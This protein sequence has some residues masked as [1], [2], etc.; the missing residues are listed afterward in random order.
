MTRRQ[1]LVAVLLS[2]GI[3]LWWLGSRPRKS[4]LRPKQFPGS[5]LQERALDMITSPLKRIYFH[6]LKVA[7]TKNTIM[8]NSI[9]SKGG[10]ATAMLTCS[11]R[12]IAWDLGF[13]PDKIAMEFA[14][15]LRK[16]GLP[17]ETA[18]AQFCRRVRWRAAR[19]VDLECF[20]TPG[21]GGIVAPLLVRNCFGDNLLQQYIFKHP[22]AQAVI[23]GA[24]FDTRFYRL[25]FLSG[26]GNL[27]LLEVDTAETLI[28]KTTAL[29]TAQIKCDHVVFVPCNFNTQN[30][31]AVLSQHGFRK[32]SPAVIVWEGVSMYL[33]RA[34]VLAMF[35][36]VAKCAKGT[37]LYF[38]YITEAAAKSP[39]VHTGEPFAFGMKDISKPALEE[40]VHLVPGLLVREHYPFAVLYERYVPRRADGHFISPVP[41]ISAIAVLEVA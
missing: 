3:S 12:G 38:D 40:F 23:L 25:P 22:S 10:S 33:T 1:R 26:V 39:V 9:S 34:K 31:L 17:H 27:S 29:S 4:S 15:H 6:N 21:G 7:Q 11:L 19:C 32:D 8:S 24:G 28:E 5:H 41:T 16:L 30:W 14:E 36:D 35:R 2:V 37:L 20:D 13:G 18:V